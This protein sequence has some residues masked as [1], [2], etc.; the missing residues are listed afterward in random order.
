MEVISVPTLRGH[1]PGGVLRLDGEIFE[2]GGHVEAWHGV[3][4]EIDNAEVV[5]VLA[6]SAR[7]LSFESWLCILTKGKPLNWSPAC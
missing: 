6:R 1:Q 4:R 5:S 2:G 3:L 7:P